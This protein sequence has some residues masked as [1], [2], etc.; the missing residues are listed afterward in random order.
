M[1]ALTLPTSAVQLNGEPHCLHPHLECDGHP[2]CDNAEDEEFWKCRPKL[3]KLKRVKKRATFYCVSKMYPRKS[4]WTAAVHC[5]GKAEC[6]GDQDEEAMCQIF[7][8]LTFIGLPATFVIMV[9]I[10]AGYKC[11]SEDKKDKKMKN[12]SE[13]KISEEV[14]AQSYETNTNKNLNVKL[15][16][17]DLLND[18]KTRI[19]G[20]CTFFRFE[21]E[22]NGRNLAQTVCSIK[23]YLYTSVYS[24][25]NEDCFPGVTRKYCSPLEDILKRLKKIK[26]GSWLLVKIKQIAVIYIDSLKDIMLVVS[27]LTIVGVTSLYN[28]PTELSSIVVFCLIFFII[29]PMLLSSLILAV[30]TIE[31]SHENLSCLSKTK[32]IAKNLILWFFNP[33]RLINKLEKVKD[34]L[35][36]SAK[37]N[38]TEEVL[39]NLEEEQKIR[40]KYTN[41]VRLDLQL[42]T[43]NQS[44]MQVGLLLLSK[45]KT[46]TTGG[47]ET[48]F[49]NTSTAYLILSILWSIKT[50]FSEHLNHVSIAKPHIRITSK[51]MVYIMAAIASSKR[52]L[53]LVMFFVPGLGLFSI[54]HHWQ[55]EQMPF[56]VSQ[57]TTRLQDNLPGML[58]KTNDGELLYLSKFGPVAWSLI[59]RSNYSDLDPLT[60]RPQPPDYTLYTGLRLLH[61]F[62]LFVLLYV[63]QTVAIFI[64]KFIVVKEFRKINMIKQFAHSLENCGIVFPL[65]DW[66]VDHGTVEEHRQRF[67]KVNREVIVTMVVNFF[68]NFVML[69]PLIYTG[70]R[71]RL[72]FT[73]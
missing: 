23:N 47:L 36:N 69:I 15:L 28:F 13:E 38:K 10:A 26:W 16:R 57:G 8:L 45:T 64:T 33:L 37:E 41:L 72:F 35:K 6:D 4:H 68:F 9:S 63:L 50:S 22:R 18:K 11:Y 20:S 54:L 7:D 56:E 5:D 14:I 21:H 71:N 27:I 73:R 25:V 59:D 67:S 55:A 46:P 1:P 29:S 48:F 51:V 31:E 62:M 30:E 42:E 58:N 66:D 43:I 52:I 44:S 24:V 53:V 39:K 17:S 65:Q 61:Y 12:C 34:N 3:I 49:E 60:Q 19:K 2:Q 70:S 32:I 40:K